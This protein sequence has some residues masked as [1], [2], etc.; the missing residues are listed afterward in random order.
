MEN[1]DVEKTMHVEPASDD[2]TARPVS[3]DQM[4]P[5]GSVDTTMRTIANPG[6][7][8]SDVQDVAGDYFVL[9]GVKYKNMS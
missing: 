6:Q 5:S 4:I 3:M 9:K 1:P 7:N 2:V 8:D